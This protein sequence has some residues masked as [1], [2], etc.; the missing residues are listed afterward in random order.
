MP[1]GVTAAA[2]RELVSTQDDAG[3]IDV[4]RNRAATDPAGARV[5]DLGRGP[6]GPSEEAVFPAV[7]LAAIHAN[8]ISGRING[9]GEHLPRLV[10]RCECPVGV[11]QV[12][13]R[14]E[15]L[16]GIVA[17]NLSRVVQVRRGICGTGR[18]VI[19]V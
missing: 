19:N 15:I 7:V 4:F 2:G 8:N 5:F 16:V 12:C 18:E 6:V 17:R 11:S 3:R 13:V 1:S 9:V 14:G 10:Q